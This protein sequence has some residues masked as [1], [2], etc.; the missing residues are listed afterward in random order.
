MAVASVSTTWWLYG[1]A[2]FLILLDLALAVTVSI[3]NIILIRESKTDSFSYSVNV[4]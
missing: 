2:V 3:T 4:A 1:T